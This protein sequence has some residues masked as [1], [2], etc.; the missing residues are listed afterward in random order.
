MADTETKYEQVYG[1]TFADYGRRDMD[2][3]IEPLATRFS[4][5]GLEPRALFAGRRCLD[6]GC[7]NGRGVLFMARH[8]AR[9]IQA[10]DFSHTNVD[11]ARRFAAAYG[12]DN[13]TVRHGTIEALPF[14]NGTFDFVWCNGVLMH[15]A[16]PNR[17]ISELARVLEP[18]GKSWIYVYGS[19]GIYWRTIHH[20][21]DLM[22]GINVERCQ[23]MLK[24]MRYEP[25]YV[26][27]FIDDW[28]AVHLR[29][30]TA[31]DLEARLAA[32]GFEPPVR[33]KWGVSYDTS[34]RFF[35]AVS[36]LEREMMGEG[37]LRYLLTKSS[38]D[39]SAAAALLDEGEY[40]SAYDWPA[41]IEAVEPAFEAF[42]EPLAGSAWS[43]VAAGAH[44]QRELRLLLSRPGDF[45]LAA[46]VAVMER[47]AA[48]A[49][50][51]TPLR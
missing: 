20:L 30:Y 24:L 34:H 9:E 17:C 49:R 45:D 8:G 46:F 16:H 10:L 38:S 27:E 41:S 11:S 36:A 26:A 29:A 42:R 43:R 3:F 18:G 33:L 13:V 37:D 2:E 23:A 15:T 40:G 7:G 48:V 1:N 12:F 51:A 44:L 39:P 22:N 32:V 35:S 6:A 21:R 5:N 28:Y 50:D 47:I 14:A 25:R 31:A 19:G 4:A